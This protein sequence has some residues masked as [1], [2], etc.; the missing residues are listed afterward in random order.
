MDLEQFRWW[1]GN[2]IKREK[3]RETREDRRE[4]KD[5]V[6]STEEIAEQTRSVEKKHRHALQNIPK[7]A[8]EN[9]LGEYFRR[10]GSRPQFGS[11][12]ELF[13]VPFGVPWGPCP[14]LWGPKTR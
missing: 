6:K 13:L 9:I 5:E 8:F 12:L 7:W 14:L 4:K 10:A 2:E 1:P 3:G 11:L